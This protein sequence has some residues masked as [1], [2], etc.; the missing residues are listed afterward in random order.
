MWLTL[1]TGIL[2]GV[3][4]AG[5][6]TGWW[7][8]ISLQADIRPDSLLTEKLQP[9]TEIPTVKAETSSVTVTTQPAVEFAPDF[10]LLGL[11]DELETHTMSQHRGGPVILNFWASWCAPC[12]AEMP[13]FQRAHEQFGS[14]GL[15]ILGVNQTFIDDI[16]AARE[17]A[18]ELDLT[19]PL[20][21]DDSGNVSSAAFDV[22]VLPTTIIIDSAG[23][24]H[25][26]HLGPMNDEQIEVVVNELAT[27]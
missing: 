10:A 1:P 5:I 15:V 27:E 24:I 22:R 25:S 4:L 16:D 18:N 14:D 2:I 7:S 12:R 23:T 9:V 21:R 3:Y 17:F 8:G 19:F 11:F 6:V 13:A 20:V 26:V